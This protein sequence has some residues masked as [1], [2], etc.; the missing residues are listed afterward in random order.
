LSTLFYRFAQVI[1]YQKRSS[2]TGLVGISSGMADIARDGILS[3]MAD[4]ARDGISSGMADI[5]RDGI[6]SGMADITRDG[7][8]SGM[9][10]ISRVILNCIVKITFSNT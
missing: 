6:S 10:D 8:L 5:A 3:G 7:I 2:P 4:I 9:A 1:L